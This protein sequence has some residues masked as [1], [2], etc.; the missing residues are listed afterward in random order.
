M[1]LLGAAGRYIG[2][3]APKREMRGKEEEIGIF[4]GFCKFNSDVCKLLVVLI[5]LDMNSIKLN[6][7]VE[8]TM[9][10]SKNLMRNFSFVIFPLFLRLTDYDRDFAE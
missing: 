2:S 9:T 5:F 7:Q 4:H 10:I 3:A 1:N 6:E 8:A